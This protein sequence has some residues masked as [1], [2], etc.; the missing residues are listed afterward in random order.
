MSPAGVRLEYLVRNVQREPVAQQL[1]D[2]QSL[3]RLR[4]TRFVICEHKTFIDQHARHVL[5][6]VQKCH[7]K[8]P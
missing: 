3:S 8:L 4:I 1:R 7:D 2:M 6:V 5:T